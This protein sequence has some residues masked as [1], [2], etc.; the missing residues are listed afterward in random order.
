MTGMVTTDMPRGEMRGGPLGEMPAAG[1]T[2]AGMP[3]AGMTSAAMGA[4]VDSG[5]PPGQMGG[6]EAVPSVGAIEMPGE[7]R[8]ILVPVPAGTK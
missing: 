1:M 4:G 7:W 6:G 5:M 2:G 8:L 3:G